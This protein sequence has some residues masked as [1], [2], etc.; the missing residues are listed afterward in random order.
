VTSVIEPVMIVVVGI[1]VG[2]VVISMY[3][4]MFKVY[5]EIK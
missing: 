1:I 5:D 4:P 3:M 2:F